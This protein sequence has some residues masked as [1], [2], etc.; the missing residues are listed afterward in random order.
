MAIVTRSIA[1][2]VHDDGTTARV[3][4]DYDDADLRIRVIRVVNQ[5][6]VAVVIEAARTDRSRVH[7][8]TFAANQTTERTVPTN[9]NNRLQLR[10]D[11][12]GR[13]DDVEYALRWS[14]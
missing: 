2:L 14:P 7:T 6:P 9:P 11:S 1:T 10:V 8:Q 13:L 12:R 3:E 5:T 4:I